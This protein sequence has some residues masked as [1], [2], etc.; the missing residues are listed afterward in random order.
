MEK[1]LWSINLTES[2]KK[3]FYKNTQKI[4]YCLASYYTVVTKSKFLPRNR[5]RISPKLLATFTLSL[6][7]TLG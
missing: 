4:K 6:Y 1:I 5:P 7:S 2:F 3:K